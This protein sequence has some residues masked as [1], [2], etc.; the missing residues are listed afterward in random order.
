MWTGCKRI[1]KAGFVNFWRNG[2]VSLAAILVMT[3]MLF[4]IGSLL[5]VGT[6]L[7]TTLEHIRDKVDINVYFVTSAP[8]EEIFDMQSSL[9]ALPE[10]ESV[11]YVSRDEALVNFRERHRNDQLTLQ[12]LDELNENPLGASLSIKAK[13]TSQYENIAAFLEGTSALTGENEPIVDNINYFQNKIAIDRLTSIIDSAERFGFFMI[14]VLAVAS[15]LI[16]FNTIRLAIYSSREEIAVM[17]LVGAS[18]MYIRGPFVFEG[19]LYGIIAALITLIIF[20][21]LT[22]WLG[23]ITENFF[24]NINVFTYYL[25][26]FTRIFFTILLSGIALGAISSYLAVRKYLKV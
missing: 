7:N 21:P 23:P 15:V 19:I 12:A 8:E 18:N 25:T 24:G 16:T 13:E 2:F 22:L 5:F 3:V 20:Y 9:E 14:V 17:R 4:T 1:L 6:I 10:V 11:T 26:D